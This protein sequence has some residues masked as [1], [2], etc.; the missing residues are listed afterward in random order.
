MRKKQLNLWKGVMSLGL[1]LTC[2]EATHYATVYYGV[3]VWQE[4]NVTLFCAADANYV[5]QEQ[6]NIWATQ[7]CVPTDPSP[8]EF[9]LE[10]VTETFDI[11]NNNMVDQMQDDIISLWDQSLKPCVK[12]TVMCV[13][14]NCTKTTETTTQTNSTNTTI[15]PYIPQLDIYNC[16]F[17]V[18]TVL[19]DK[20]TKQQALFYKQDI[21]KTDETNE[22]KEYSEYR[23]INC[24]TSTISQA[25]P[26]VS[27]EP[28][29][30]QYC[31]PAGYALMKCNDKQ[32][33]GTGE[34]KN[35]SI[36]HCTHGIRPTVSTQLILN[37]TLA[38]EHA[39]IIS[40]NSTD[41]GKDIIVKLARSVEI[42]CERT[43]NNTR[44]QIQVGPM[45]IYNSENIVGNTRKAFCKYNKTNWQ[46]ALKDTVRALKANQIR[47]QNS[48]GGDPEVT[49]LHFNCH[50]EFF[51]CDTTKMFN[52]NCTKESC[53]CITGNC[54]NYIP[55]HLKQVVMSWMRVGSGLFAPP[56]RGTL[57]CKSNITG[58]ILQR[59]VPLNKT[60]ENSTDYNTLRPIG[61]DMTNIWR[62]ELYPYKVVK[63][64]ALSVA[65]TKARRPVI[66]HN[67]EKRAA[68]L[69]MLFLGF[70]SAAGSTM[71]AAAVTLTV[72]ARQVL[73][74]IVQQQNNMLRAIAA[75]QELLRLSVWGI[76]Q[77]RA[78]LLAIETYLR[79]QQLLGLWGCTGRLI[80]YTN[81][82]WNKT[83]TGKNETELDDIWGNMTWQQWDKLVDNYTDT[84]FLEI[85][86]AQEQQEV[87]EKAL[88]ELDKW[89]DLWSWLDITQWLWYI[90]I[91]IMII[92]GLVGL[93]I[94]MAIINMCHRV[95]QG[96]SPLSFQILA[97][98]QV[99]AGIV[100]EIGEEGGRADSDRSIRLL[101]GFLPLIWDDLRTLIVWI[102]RTLVILLSGIKEI[103]LSLIEHLTRLLRRVNNLTRDCFAFIAYWGQELK[104]SAIS[105]LD[106]VAVWTADWTDQVI[107]IAQRIGRGILNIPRRIRQGL[108]RSLL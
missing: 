88:L 65:P 8:I 52:Y 30:I 89:A 77:L 43:S 16:S 76:R 66:S 61:G 57:R 63:V 103:T 13:T 102:Y 37:G 5:S 92:A 56:I 7:A 79:D 31:A 75:Q 21:I 17:N 47:F 85:Q 6:H 95:R 60:N 86:K 68:G 24:N 48:S 12:L 18:T 39:T 44:G 69:G 93:R 41:S 59:D 2:I 62:S 25:C 23:L 34:C 70:M 1:I 50:G 26:K 99:P 94:L 78:R 22:T 80:C 20:K 29:P 36:V 74:G 101:A 38:K 3:P 11:W 72:Q 82:P 90:K 64:K 9:P 83:W 14:L 73:H 58:I 55:C 19:K 97:R 45:T 105:L 42:T 53:D 49:F 91:F 84:I 108:E 81:V 40:K 100:P 35:V 98:N 96:Y 87:N 33:N 67:R 46:N 27:F 106:C 51:Y 10:N 107:A 71:G 4:A 15:P 54:T 32:F 104:Q 28:L